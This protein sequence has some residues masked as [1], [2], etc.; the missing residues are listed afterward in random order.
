MKCTNQLLSILIETFC[1]KYLDWTNL[2]K[3]SV[4][5]SF[6]IVFAILQ[7]TFASPEAWIMRYDFWSSILI[8]DR[9]DMTQVFVHLSETVCLADAKFLIFSELF[10]W[11]DRGHITRQSAVPASCF[12]VR[13]L[14]G[15]SG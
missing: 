2:I 10:S 12:D 4:K 11:S 1:I 5:T 15:G 8:L 9:V 3:K 6:E 13:L 7:G 14:I